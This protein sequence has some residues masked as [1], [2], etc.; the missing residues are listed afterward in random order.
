MFVS[1]FLDFCFVFHFLFVIVVFSI[2]SVVQFLVVVFCSSV[3][4]DISHCTSEFGPGRPI[5]IKMWA[6]W[7][8]VG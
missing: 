2:L 8:D 1:V 3:F 6:M 7:V 5:S 4:K